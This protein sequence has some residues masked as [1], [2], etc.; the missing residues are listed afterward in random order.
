MVLNY[1]LLGWLPAIIILPYISAD[2][3]LWMAAGGILY[4]IG[5]VFL[6]WDERIPFFHAIWHVMVLAA[7]ACQW[8]AVL[9]FTVL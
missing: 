1:I 8:Y 7:A 9:Q 2:C 5:T 6:C 4:T 3:I